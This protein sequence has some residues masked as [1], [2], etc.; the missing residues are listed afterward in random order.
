MSIR[1]LTDGTVEFDKPKE[2][3]YFHKLQQRL[4]TGSEKT[5]RLIARKQLYSALDSPLLTDRDFEEIL[6]AFGFVKNRSMLR[7]TPPE[8][9]PGEFKPSNG[10]ADEDYGGH[11]RA[12]AGRPSQEPGTNNISYNGH[13][14]NHF[15]NMMRMRD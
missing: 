13:A 3:V 10:L 8:D 15:E 5:S 11:S 9:F 7:T 14:T 12:L 6:Q 1:I 2:A 4:G